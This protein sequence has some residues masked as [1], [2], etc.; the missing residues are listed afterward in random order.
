MSAA[1]FVIQNCHF[2]GTLIATTS[3]GSYVGGICGYIKTYCSI[4]DCTS[5]GEIR[6]ASASNVGGIC[7]YSVGNATTK[8]EISGCA[9]IA[10]MSDESLF[11][12]AW[13]T[14]KVALRTK[15]GFHIYGKESIKDILG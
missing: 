1:P 6:S 9:S 10:L 7:G 14:W 11:E 8:N 12:V 4:K 15:E 13:T 2:N 3:S 5:A